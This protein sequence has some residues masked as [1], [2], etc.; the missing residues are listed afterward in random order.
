[1]WPID[2]MPPVPKLTG[3]FCAWIQATSSFMFFAGTEGCTM[4]TSGTVAMRLT[5]L[6]FLS[7]S[8][9]GGVIIAGA[10][11]IGVVFEASRL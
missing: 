7:E 2:P 1:M 9:G 3:F 8:Y 6:K 4:T 11:E 10:S 5:W